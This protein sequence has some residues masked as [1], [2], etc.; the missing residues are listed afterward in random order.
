[1]LGDWH[2]G[3]SPCKKLYTI[4]AGVYHLTVQISFGYTQVRHPNI[5][6]FKDTLELEEKHETV[7]YVVTEPVTPLE[8]LL[9]ELDVQG[10]ARCDAHRIQSSAAGLASGH[11]LLCKGACWSGWPS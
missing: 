7:I 5:L 4:T 9:A 11:A 1:M 6:A 2:S 8:E 3:P 10:E